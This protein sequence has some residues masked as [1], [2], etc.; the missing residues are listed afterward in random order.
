MLLC[1][2]RVE[3]LSC[4]CYADCIVDGGSSGDLDQRV[5]SGGFL[6]V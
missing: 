4:L 5:S 6:L 3:N 2:R 1:E